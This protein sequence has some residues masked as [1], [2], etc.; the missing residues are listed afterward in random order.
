MVWIYAAF[1][2][3]S[4]NNKKSYD[5]LHS[6][7]T[8]NCGYFCFFYLIKIFTNL[9]LPI[10]SVKFSETFKF[11][12]K[13]VEMLSSKFNVSTIASAIRLRELGFYVRYI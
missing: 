1:P 12:I 10:L 4:F 9:F 8:M 3:R 11:D 7:P 2:G 6:S 13:E 5:L